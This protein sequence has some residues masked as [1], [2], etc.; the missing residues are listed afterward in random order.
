MWDVLPSQAATLEVL[1]TSHNFGNI[2][3]A[4][5]RNS[6]AHFTRLRKLSIA[7]NCLSQFTDF[8]FYDEVILGWQLEELDLSDVK[9]SFSHRR[10]FKMAC[11]NGRC[12]IAK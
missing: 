2:D 3:H 4:V 6:L 5:I 1:D 9:V 12:P 7:G 10:I 8:L 11:T